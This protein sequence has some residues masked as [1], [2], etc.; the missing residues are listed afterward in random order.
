MHHLTRALAVLLAICAALPLLAAV[1]ER[2]LPIVAALFLCAV[3]F[4]YL[5]SRT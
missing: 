3:A 5:L 2:V 4:S 1:A